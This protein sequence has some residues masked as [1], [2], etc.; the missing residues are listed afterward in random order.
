MK[1]GH[2]RQREQ[3]AETVEH[4]NKDFDEIAERVFREEPPLPDVIGGSQDYTDEAA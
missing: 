3:Q 1:S 4:A 2:S